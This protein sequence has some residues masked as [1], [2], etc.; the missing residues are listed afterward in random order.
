MSAQFANPADTPLAQA[1]ELAKARQSR[2]SSQ[3]P[4]VTGHAGPVDLDGQGGPQDQYDRQIY[5]PGRG[6]DW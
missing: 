2:V 3:S 5:T 4:M 6:T 1:T